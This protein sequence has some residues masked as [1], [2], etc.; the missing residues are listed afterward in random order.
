MQNCK[1]LM[2]HTSISVE[3]WEKVYYNNVNIRFVL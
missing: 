1:I 3:K 2:M